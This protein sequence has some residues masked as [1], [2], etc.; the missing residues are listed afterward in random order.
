M[1]YKF[2]LH[3]RSL[4][5]TLSMMIKL[6]QLIN[7]YKKRFCKFCIHNIKVTQ[8]TLLYTQ[9]VQCRLQKSHINHFHA[10]VYCSM[11]NTLA[12]LLYFCNA[13]I[14][15]ILLRELYSSTNFL[16]YVKCHHAEINKQMA[17]KFMNDSNRRNVYNY[18]EF[19]IF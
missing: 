2:V 14:F 10:T 11:A 4:H 17:D 5:N 8:M 19:D 3:F 6:T 7:Q 12:R 9:C 16:W 1:Q 18:I 13:N 15:L